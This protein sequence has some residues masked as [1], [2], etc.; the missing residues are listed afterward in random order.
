MYKFLDDNFST[1]VPGPDPS[2]GNAKVEIEQNESDKNN[3]SSSEKSPEDAS[4][5]T[6]GYKFKKDAKSK[7]KSPGSSNH[8][9]TYSLVRNFVICLG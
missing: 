4:A 6:P 9:R 8:R 1:Q 5:K 7:D 2:E 3:I